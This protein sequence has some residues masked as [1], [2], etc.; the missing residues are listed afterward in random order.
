[1]ERR[2]LRAA[3]CWVVERGWKEGTCTDGP[4]TQ[5]A[6]DGTVPLVCFFYGPGNW[7]LPLDSRDAQ[8]EKKKGKSFGTERVPIRKKEQNQKEKKK[9]GNKNYKTASFFG[10]DGWMVIW[11]DGWIW[12]PKRRRFHPPPLLTS[13]LHSIS[14]GGKSG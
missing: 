11:M 7:A 13:S 12:P 9:E 8:K 4:I 1:M 10:M 2:V 6:T 3:S 14:V 5:P